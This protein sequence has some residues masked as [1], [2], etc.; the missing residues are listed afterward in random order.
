VWEELAEVMRL[1][2][3]QEEDDLVMPGL[4]SALPDDVDPFNVVVTTRSGAVW[5]K[6][7]EE[8]PPLRTFGAGEVLTLTAPLVDEDSWVSVRVTS[9]LAGFAHADEVRSPLGHKLING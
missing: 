4:F 8:G 5:P 6:A 1:G 3:G 7:R 2:C 9:T